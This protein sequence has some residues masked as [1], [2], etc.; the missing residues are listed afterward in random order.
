MTPQELRER[1]ERFVRAIVEF[2]KPLMR[3]PGTSDVARQLLRA[4]TSV[5]ANYRSAGRGRS[6]AEFTARIG[7]V[8]EEADECL[9][10]LELLRDSTL[11]T[12][13]EVEKLVQ[14]A[15]ELV[16]IFS[17]SRRTAIKNRR[18]RDRAISRSKDRQSDN[19]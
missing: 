17:A 10:W 4:A 19:P 18:S 12:G 11:A 9:Y 14:E 15:R 6:H 3:K 2:A 16:A 5:G 7:L 13:E 8:L 1:T